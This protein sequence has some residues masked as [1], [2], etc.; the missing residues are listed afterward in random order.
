MLK[1][2]PQSNN[3]EPGVQR[4]KNIAFSHVHQIMQIVSDWDWK[5]NGGAVGREEEE[6]VQRDKGSKQW[7][8]RV[9]QKQPTLSTGN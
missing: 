9:K 2:G 6:S 1:R 8:W 7:H 4:E 5:G 3:L